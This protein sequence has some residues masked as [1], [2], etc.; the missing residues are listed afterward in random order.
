MK[1]WFFSI[2]G[3][4]L[5]TGC[6]N[7]QLQKPL[8]NSIQKF[9]V[10]TTS[11]GQQNTGDSGSQNTPAGD[12]ALP[13]AS[14]IQVPPADSLTTGARAD[15]DAMGGNLSAG[16]RS[17]VDA[18]Q[19][20]MAT[21]QTAAPSI[22]N[23]L[24]NS[25]DVNNIINI[26]MDTF[27][28]EHLSQVL[29]FKTASGIKS[30]DI[31]FN[32]SGDFNKLSY[33]VLAQNKLLTEFKDVSLKIQNATQLKN[34]HYKLKALCS[35][36]NC[37][38]LFITI[39]KSDDQGTIVESYPNIYKKVDGK[40]VN[41]EFSK[42]QKEYMSLYKA[43]FR[44]T[45]NQAPQALVGK[46]LRQYLEKNQDNISQLVEDRIQ[47]GGNTLA[48]SNEV[49]QADN[50]RYDLFNPEISKNKEGN[51]M[52][53][54][55]LPFT[56]NQNSIHFQGEIQTSSNAQPTS[57]QSTNPDLKLITQ[58]HIPDQIYLLYFDQSHYKS[59]SEKNN[60]VTKAFQMAVCATLNVSYQM[61]TK[62]QI[63]S[64]GWL[65][66]NAS[67]ADPEIIAKAS[68]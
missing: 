60:Q 9:D 61:F 12:Q 26:L 31:Q 41:S 54:A 44:E 36:A 18:A 65:L 52:I 24:L 47:K 22:Q 1:L 68:K 55:D 8:P 17:D 7:F 45:M 13:G 66:G 14:A 46:I 23:L 11:P 49:L 19:N 62:C 32:I 67:N 20:A 2:L 56:N 35:G 33:E 40:Y 42:K 51:L 30:E 63:I 28:A 10:K 21:A 25:D 53:S 29:T 50:M 6:D 59:K 27:S 64:T 48:Y 57:I 15:A 4:S 3:L 16:S 34:D 5:L 39:L 43:T 58:T 37:E 38:V